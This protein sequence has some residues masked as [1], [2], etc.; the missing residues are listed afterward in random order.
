MGSVMGR[1]EQTDALDYGEVASPLQFKLP[2]YWEVNF[3][4]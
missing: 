4:E 1:S 3:E 2:Q